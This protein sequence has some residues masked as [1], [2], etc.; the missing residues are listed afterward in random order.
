MA[1]SNPNRH[2]VQPDDAQRLDRLSEEIRGRLQEIGLIV[3]RVTGTE[4]SGGAVVKFVPRE[5]KKA[6]VDA[7]D[8]DWVEIV[9]IEPD[10]NYCYGSIGGEKFAESPCGASG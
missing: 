8:S 7:E 5:A 3:A 2:D 6:H 1:E 9:D 10:T 4:Q